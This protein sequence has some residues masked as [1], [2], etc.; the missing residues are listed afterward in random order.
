MASQ[1]LPID[2]RG[3]DAAGRQHLLEGSGLHHATGIEHDDA[4]GVADRAEPMGTT[5]RVAPRADMVRATCAWVALSSALVASSRSGMRG[6]RASARASMMRC[7][8]PPGSSL[9][10]R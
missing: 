2:H 3:E 10:R 8:W 4:V 7:F 5:T 9:R 6:R 1:L